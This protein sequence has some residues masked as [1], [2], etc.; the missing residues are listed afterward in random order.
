MIYVCH[1]LTIPLA[2][3]NVRSEKMQKSTFNYIWVKL[4]DRS[5][6]NIVI[7]DSQVFSD[8]QPRLSVWDYFHN[9][10]CCG[11]MPHFSVIQKRS[12]GIQWIIFGAGLARKELPEVYHFWQPTDYEVPT[13]IF[14]LDFHSLVWIRKRGYNSTF[15]SLIENI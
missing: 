15:S 11:I 10:V 3:L 13:Q 5:F 12:K 7:V 8:F 9:V 2:Q 1:T 14:C 6:P 4:D